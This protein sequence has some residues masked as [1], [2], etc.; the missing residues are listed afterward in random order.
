MVHDVTATFSTEQAKREGAYPIDMYIVNASPTGTDYMYYVNL[1]NDVVGYE[2]N[3]TGDVTSATTV[4]NRAWIDRD[5][6]VSNTQEEIEGVS[7]SIPNVDRAMESIIQ[8]K[9][10]LRGRDVYIVTFFADNLPSGDAAKFIGASPN[11][12][13]HIK[14]KYYVDNV[15]TNE[16]AVI[17]H[18]KSK[19]DI[20]YIQ[21]PGRKFTHECQWYIKGLYLA[22]E[23]DYNGSINSA[24]YPTCDG[25]LTNCTERGNE[26]RFGGFISIPS[27]RITIA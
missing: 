21:I 14:E 10:Y 26:K 17:F 7:I 5:S 25:T 8:S 4:Y 18:C 3:A 19:F 16:Q 6:I 20:K 1:N 15:D 2:L 24:S 9:N 27:R 12:Q 22:S 23:C 13:S 11:H